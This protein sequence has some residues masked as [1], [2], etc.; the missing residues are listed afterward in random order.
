MSATSSA[1]NLLDELGYYVIE[2]IKEDRVIYVLKRTGRGKKLVKRFRHISS[3]EE[4]IKASCD[5]IESVVLKGRK[6][7]VVPPKPDV[8]DS[9][10]AVKRC[11]RRFGFKLSDRQY[12]EVCNK[13]KIEQDA[14]WLRESGERN[15]YIWAVKI[16]GIF[17][18]V[19]YDAVKEAV[20][21]VLPKTELIG[22]DYAN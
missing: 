5:F 10:H 6:K 20:I 18:P 14:Y 8:I 13:I 19:V 3:Y 15:R 17:I 9:S 11:K 22:T 4:A 12:K 16:A 21:T 1:N 7:K 2:E